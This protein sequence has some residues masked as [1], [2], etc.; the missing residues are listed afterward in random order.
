MKYVYPAI[1]TP[2]E[3][4]GYSVN[5]PDIPNCFTGGATLAEALENAADVL[6]LMLFKREERGEP[7]PF[8]TNIKEVHG[9][10]THVLADTAIYQRDLLCR[11]VKKTLTIPRWL[12]ELAE[13]AGLPYS[14]LLQEALKEKLGVHSYEEFACKR[15]QN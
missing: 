4:G 7:V 3:E 13:E 10:T 15:A 2:E 6:A 14:Y 11:A 5:F 8:P 9:H 1:L 12:H